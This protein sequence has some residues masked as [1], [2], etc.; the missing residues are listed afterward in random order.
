MAAG[1]RCRLY[2]A[3]SRDDLPSLFRTWTAR[4]FLQQVQPLIERVQG[5]V[6]AGWAEAE[7][8]SAGPA[9]AAM[10]PVDPRRHGSV[11]SRTLASDLFV[12]ALV[13]SSIV[14]LATVTT[15]DLFWNRLNTGLTLAQLA[16]AIVVLVQYSRGIVGKAMQRVA[17]ASM[18][19]AG[20]TFYVQTFSFALIGA[21][22]ATADFRSMMV[23][24]PFMVAH[25]VTYGLDLL[26]GFISAVITLRGA[27][28]D[29]TDII[30]D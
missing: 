18:V 1:C 17:V 28:N 30:K 8:S 13:V 24:R 23:V 16:G 25:Q 3:V 10:A 5:V 22:R 7:R 2:T 9:V 14:G 15:P 6:E 4:R 21:A 20:V 29:E 26:L 12:L 11:P 27:Y 19:L